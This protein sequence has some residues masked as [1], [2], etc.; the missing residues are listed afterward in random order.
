[1]ATYLT[2]KDLQELIRVD[3]STIYRMA[4]DGRLPA[5]KV[6]RQWRFPEHEVMGWLGAETGGAAMHVD[7]HLGDLVSPGVAGAIAELAAAALGATVVIT[8]MD[9]GPL[10]PVANPCGLFKAIAAD[11]AVLPRCI[12]TWRKYGSAP[13]LIPRFAPSEF[14]FLCARAF[15]RR[16]TRLLGMVIAGGIAP[17]VWPPAPAEVADIAAALGVPESAVADH[18][19]EVFRLSRSDQGRLLG[20]L[21]RVALLV[22]QIA[23]E[24]GAMAG[25]STGER[26]SQ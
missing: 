18:I 4:E 7:D 14:G 26:R 20:L 1:V 12:A 16:D 11:P 25:A 3:K 13:D 2:A 15:V 10:A 9:G 23:D 6:G 22:S 17:E 5:V 19:S 8:G 24:A 21:P